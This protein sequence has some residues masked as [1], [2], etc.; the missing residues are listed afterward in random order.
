MA[1]MED[2]MFDVTCPQQGNVNRLPNTKPC[3][4]IKQSMLCTVGKDRSMGWTSNFIFCF[5]NCVTHSKWDHMYTW[6]EF[7]DPND[8]K[9]QPELVCK[10]SELLWL[11]LTSVFY[12]A[13]LDLT[14]PGHAILPFVLLAWCL[15][16][17]ALCHLVSV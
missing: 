12:P 17:L 5:W 15:L 7:C 6:C 3:R 8:I 4:A 16:S 14:N 1:V 2:W 10:G 9:G 13:V 11:S